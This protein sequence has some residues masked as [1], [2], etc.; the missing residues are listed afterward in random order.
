VALVDA[1]AGLGQAL[2]LQTVA[3]GIESSEQW[4]TLRRIGIDHGQ[5]YLFGRPVD[6]ATIRTLLEEPAAA[7][8][9]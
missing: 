6:A 8:A 3:E 5:G 4:D 2:K 9:M 1:V 7:E